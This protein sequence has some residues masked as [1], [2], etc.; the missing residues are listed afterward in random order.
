MH[1][2]VLEA[3]LPSQGVPAIVGGE[4]NE[5]EVVNVVVELAGFERGRVFHGEVE[6]EL[7]FLVALRRP[8]VEDP[9][10]AG[11]EAVAPVGPCGAAMFPFPVPGVDGVEAGVGFGQA[12][13][14]FP[15]EQQ[16]LLEEAAVDIG[17]ELDHGIT[18]PN[19]QASAIVA[20]GE[21]GDGSG[22]TRRSSGSRA[23][24][25]GGRRARAARRGRADDERS[26]QR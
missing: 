24:G 26:L 11:E 25:F 15:G 6:P 2:H 18:L 8:A 21:G 20:G 3:G 23:G 12:F 5:A 13:D 19:L 7:L 22:R 1:K 9:H 10:H 16:G 4:E 17:F 14:L